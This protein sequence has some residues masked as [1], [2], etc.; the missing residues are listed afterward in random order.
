MRFQTPTLLAFLLSFTLLTA[1]NSCQTN[2]SR[3]A[4]DDYDDSLALVYTPGKERNKIDDF[5]EQLH[6]RRQFNGNVL[7][8]RKGKIIYQRAIG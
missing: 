6:R 4:E 7:I 5:V 2:L 1:C 3:T 8:A